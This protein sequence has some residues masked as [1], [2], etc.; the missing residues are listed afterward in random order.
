MRRAA[1]LLTEAI[2]HLQDCFGAN[3]RFAFEVVRYTAEVVKAALQIPPHLE[4][5]AI[6]FN[7]ALHCYEVYLV[8][9]GLPFASEGALCMGFSPED[10]AARVTPAPEG[11]PDAKG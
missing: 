7:P 1:R 2:P 5:T 11:G 6:Q 10:F 9:K 4:I 8:G 3:C